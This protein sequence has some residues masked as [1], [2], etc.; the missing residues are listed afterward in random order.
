[1]TK[2]S[3]KLKTFIQV[4]QNAM[5]FSIYV[6]SL[7][8]SLLQ[9]VLNSKSINCMLDLFVDVLV[10][11]FIFKHQ[12]NTTF[13]FKLTLYCQIILTNLNCPVEQP[14]IQ[15]KNRKRIK[16]YIQITFNILNCFRTV[17]RTVQNYVLFYSPKKRTKFFFS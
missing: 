10:D 11:I 2:K 8:I 15:Q 7:S 12:K 13:F 9:Y 17:F 4:H 14:R 3:S 5:H 16:N 1:M 6:I